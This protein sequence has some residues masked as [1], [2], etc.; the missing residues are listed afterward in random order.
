MILGFAHLTATT[1]DAKEARRRWL[2]R[3]WTESHT[4]P[5]VVSAAAKWPLMTGK[6]LLHDLYMMSGDFWVEIIQ[7]DTGAVSGSGRVVYRDGSGA[8]ALAILARDPDTEVSFFVD[9]LSFTAGAGGRVCLRSRF[10]QWSITLSVTADAAAPLD[11]PLDLDGLSCLAFYST[12]V[13]ED[14]A[15][16]AGCGGRDAIDPFE[17]A[18]RDR[19]LRVLMLRSPEGTIIELI[20]I[21][22]TKASLTQ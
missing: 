18:V 20:Q 15:R 1:A 22:N 17:I 9:A 8:D 13:V 10:P 11:P 7:H 4:V 14:A 3:G 2:A 21:L 19:K 16:I 6:A 12:N 5:G